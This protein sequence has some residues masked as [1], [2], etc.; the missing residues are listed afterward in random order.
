[1]GILL[2]H[3]PKERGA[4][5]KYKLVSLDL[6]GPTTQGAVKKILLF[7]DFSEGQ[8]DVTLKI[9]PPQTELLSRAHLVLAGLVS[10]ELS[11][12]TTE[13]LSVFLK[14]LVA[15]EIHCMEI[16]RKCQRIQL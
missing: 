10:A 4:G 14:L 1:V 5:R 7:S 11:S 15:A 13:Q 2:Q 9:I 3:S 12:P 6:S 8:T 16:N